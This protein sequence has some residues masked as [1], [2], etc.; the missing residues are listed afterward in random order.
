MKYYNKKTRY[1]FTLM[2][3]LIALS[4]VILIFAAIYGSYRA[5][6][7]SISHCEPRSIIEQQARLFLQRITSELRCCYAGNLTPSKNSKFQNSI[8]M[9][10]VQEK[11]TKEDFPLFTGKT[12]FSGKTFLK[13]A[14]SSFASNPNSNMGGL[15][16]IS[17]KLDESGNVL[18]RNVRRYIEGFSNENKNDRWFP[19]LSN[20]KSI[21]FEYFADEKWIKEWESKNS[22]ILPQAVRITL[23][24]ETGQTGPLSFVSSAFIMCSRSLNSDT[25]V[26]TIAHVTD[27]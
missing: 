2:E 10:S 15:A 25:P 7:A 16:I 18:L 4:I 13:F 26:K 8:K 11:A 23:V 5:T 17:Y 3:M 20:V 27:L 12:V 9:E 22:N 14:T 6:T 1:A 19:V 21:S 24:M